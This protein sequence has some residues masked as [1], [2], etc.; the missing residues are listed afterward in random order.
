MFNV[1]AL[2]QFWMFN[3]GTESTGVLMELCL[4]DFGV[5][6]FYLECDVIIV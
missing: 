4:L 3:A 2:W 1:D 6:L 5:I